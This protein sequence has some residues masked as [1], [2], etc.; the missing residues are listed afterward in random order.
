MPNPKSSVNVG[1]A[2]VRICDLSIIDVNQSGKRILDWLDHIV[3]V[4]KHR[5]PF[6]IV[7]HGQLQPTAEGSIA[8]PKLCGFASDVL[9]PFAILPASWFAETEADP[10]RRTQMRPLA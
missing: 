1:L 6:V 10:L 2:C 7:D 9:L 5:I 3:M 8:I 4:D